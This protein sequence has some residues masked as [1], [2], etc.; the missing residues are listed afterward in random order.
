MTRG[1]SASI[2]LDVAKEVAH[3]KRILAEVLAARPSGTRQRLA[4][5]LGKNRSFISHIT[6]PDYPTPIPAVHVETILEVCH[7]PGE[8]KREFLEAFA[9]AHPRRLAVVTSGHRQR[10]LTLQV[11][12]LGSPAKNERFT[13]LL[14]AFARDLASLFDEDGT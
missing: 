1:R 8:T 10:T 13:R 14:A 6:N 7:F 3:Y 11:P 5:A 12:D 2:N 4:R 9:H